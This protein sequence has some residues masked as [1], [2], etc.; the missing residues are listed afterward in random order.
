MA[1][2]FLGVP[3]ERRYWALVARHREGVWEIA[4]CL[5][6]YALPYGAIHVTTFQQMVAEVAKLQAQAKEQ[7]IQQVVSDE[8]D[9]H[10][11][12]QIEALS[13]VDI[14][15]EVARRNAEHE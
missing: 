15:R 14:Q 4:A 8:Y 5:D 3:G 13:I 6:L 2:A 9:W 12:V 1:T 10:S 7:K 11:F